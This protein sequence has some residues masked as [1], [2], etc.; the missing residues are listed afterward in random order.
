MT[1][2]R[3]GLLVVAIVVL[4][5]TTAGSCD[6]PSGDKFTRDCT[7]KGGHVAKGDR[8]SRVCLPP[9]GGWQ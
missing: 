6:S 7:A 8:G 5:A 3:I 2:T 1:R 4:V 9:T